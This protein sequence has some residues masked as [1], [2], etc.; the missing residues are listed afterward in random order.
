VRRTASRPALRALADATERGQL[1]GRGFDRALR[2]ARTIADLDGAAAI[3][4]E[5]AL[6]ALAHRLP[7]RGSGKPLAGARP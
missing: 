6:E 3:A 5:H 2:V 4:L 7:L 1:T